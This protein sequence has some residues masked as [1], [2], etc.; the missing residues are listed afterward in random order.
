MTDTKKKKVLLIGWDG[1]DWEHINPLMD[2][3][4]LPTLESLVNEGTIANLATLQP[5]L[6]PMLWNSVATC[7]FADKHGIHGFVEPDEAGGARPYSSL[8]RKT[9]AIWNIFSQS[10]I[11]SNVINWWASHPA[12]KINGC[13]VSNLFNG[14]RID[15]ESGWQITPG[16]IHPEEKEQKYA[17]MKFFPNEM[18]QEHILPFIPNAPE[19]DQ[20]KDK[21][22]SSFAKTFAEMMTTHSIATGVMEMEPW[23]FMAIYYTGIDHFSH[24]F[25]E[26]HP[27]KLDRISEEDFEMYKDV[28]KGAY[29]FHD[30]M[31]ARI[32]ELADDDTTVV[33]CS[34]HGFQSGAFRPL[35]TPREP[36]GPA[37]WHRQ[38]GILVMK[39]PGIKKDERI[40]G[41]SLID[42]GP[43]LLHLYGLPIG[44]DMDGRV[45]IEAF[46]NPAQTETIPSW[47]DVPGDHGM[48]DGNE[49]VSSAKSEE[50]LKQF[51]ALGYVED[52]GGD[53][54]KQALAAKTEAQ[55]NLCRCLIWQNRN[56][57]AKTILEE[58]LQR[59]PWENR[60]IIQLADCYYRAGYLK[61][62]S[63]LIENSFEL[64]TTSTYQVIIIYAK[65]QLALG[66]N[67]K[68]LKSLAMASRRSPRFPKLHA[69]IGD[70]FSKLRNWE[71]AEKSY[72]QAIEL[73][74]D[75]ALAYQGLAHVYL[76]TGRVDECIDAALSALGL[77]HRLPKA[78]LS[79]GIA[80]SRKK[81]FEKATLAFR[82]SAKFAPKVVHPHRW[83]AKVYGMLGKEKL[84][85][86][87]MRKVA[88]LSSFVET[89]RSESKKRVH[90]EFEIPEI[91]DESARMETLLKERPSPHDPVEESGKTF[92]LVSGLPRSGTS[93]MMQMLVAGGM[94]V[95][96][97]GMREADTDNPKGYFEW[98][99]IKQIGEK[100]E[101]LDDVEYNGKA[102]K[103][104]SM[105]L[106][107][108]P[109]QHTY[110]VI[111][112]MRP[113][114]E[115]AASQ[116]KMIQR[117]GTEGA[118][119]E[120]SRLVRELARHR[121]ES[122][123]WLKEAKNVEHILVEYPSL[124]G[125]PDTTINEVVDF[126]G[127]DY[128]SKPEEMK[129]A[130]DGSLYRN[131][132][133]RKPTERSE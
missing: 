112:M 81:D 77:I 2:A 76:R 62:A 89:R 39:G 85:D 95:I 103:A 10:G 131:K 49:T 115:I 119:V 23:D 42:V 109:R 29:Q 22:L 108:M 106:D 12:E 72:L 125:E 132:V 16:T 91:A 51:V 96:S 9:K 30:M 65:I 92:V 47:D 80:L 121:A 7:K 86:E 14:V 41:A 105:L 74:P 56:D 46:E 68:G 84:A 33:L 27:P 99:A 38:Y 124:I 100:P 94:D 21:R 61:Q 129:S 45:L 20:K 102:L 98:E 75:L 54:E 122:V 116:T 104:I 28:I 128:L 32:L 58:L 3:G 83:L 107:K 90:E 43:T 13:V 82:N 110:K 127:S 19:I 113:V 44:Q 15:P 66:E 97:D 130:I 24:G 67:Q 88:V 71:Q 6:S 1:A 50:L 53:K 4:L 59:A 117:L 120:E 114:R 111:F 60:F 69:Q 73:H 5:V 34:D 48:P 17:E 78:H 36:A 118:E 87:H 93:L 70:V 11:K 55:Y 79:L 101:L 123:N 133:A 8:S 18:G 37:V 31:L 52:F 64:E 26:Y 63:K 57:E 25:M 35:G 126:L 40:Y